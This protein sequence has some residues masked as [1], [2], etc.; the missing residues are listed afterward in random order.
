MGPFKVAFF[1]FVE[2]FLAFPKIIVYSDDVVWNT[3]G[4]VEKQ[5][6]SI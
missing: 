1:I 3:L 5:W 4:R 2:F 6:Q